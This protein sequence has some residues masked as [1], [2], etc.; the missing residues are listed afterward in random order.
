MS[1]DTAYGLIEKNGV[2]SFCSVS[3]GRP[4][5]SDVVAKY[6][7]VSEKKLSSPEMPMIVAFT[8]RDRT[9]RTLKFHAKSVMLQC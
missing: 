6:I 4:N 8:N 2:I 9:T 3:F 1:F 5:S 7:L